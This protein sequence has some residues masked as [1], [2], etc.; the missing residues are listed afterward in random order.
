MLK[1]LIATAIIAFLASSW[2]WATIA[3]AHVLP[4]G[5]RY[6]AA[7]ERWRPLVKRYFPKDARGQVD[8][9]LQQRALAVIEAE[10]GGSVYSRPQV[11][12][13]QLSRCHGSY[14]ARLDRVTSTRISARL[15]AVGGWHAW[16]VSRRL[17]LR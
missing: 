4:V 15:Y 8:R 11:G 2:G 10:S 6:P 14:W 16:S 7:V 5:K 3:E 13:W 17:G 12:A 9:G 1:R